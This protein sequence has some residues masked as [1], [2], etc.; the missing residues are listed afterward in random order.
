ME[1]DGAHSRRTFLKVAG[2]AAAAVSLAGCLGGGNNGGGGGGGGNDGPSGTLVYSRGAPSATL[3]PQNSTS[4]EDAKVINQIYN[5]LVQFKPGDVSLEAGLAKKYELSGKTATLTLREGVKFHNDEEFTAEDFKATFRRF[6]DP[7]YEYYP[8]D[9]Y[10]SGYAAIT[11]GNWV[12]TVNAKDKYKLEIQLKQK[13]APFLRNLAMFASAVLSKKAIEEKNKKL[14]KEPVGTGPFKLGQYESNGERIQLEYNDNY[15][16]KGPKVEQVIFSTIPE[17]STRAETLIGGDA[18]IIDGLG[19]TASQK[20]QKADGVKLNAFEGVNTGYMA[21]NMER[22]KPFRKKKVRQAISYAINTKVIVENI[23][24]GFAVQASQ[25]IPSNMMGYNKDLDPYPHDVEK[26]KT[27]LKEAGHGDGISFELATFKN[28]RSYNPSP[29][30]AAQ[31]VRSDLSNVGIEI[32]INQMSFD[33]FLNYTDSGKHDACF[34]GWMSDNADPDNF[35]YSLLHP[36]VES[37]A[38]QDW[39]S[40]DTEGYNTLSVSGWANKEYMKTVEDAQKM[41]KESERKSLYQKA[42]K[43]AHDEAPWVFLDHAKEL[44]GVSN[45]VSG[46]VPSAIG[47]PYLNL[48]SV[49]G[50]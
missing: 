7:E 10:I 9:T 8:G 30:R 16:G 20:V 15:W 42:A 38:G 33:P 29:L 34:L 26:A 44:R 46:Y 21:F 49:G 11:L 25:P 14:N 27:L 41:L 36:G 48:V 1:E 28:P 13:F 6:T 3:D 35:Y 24:S 43:I 47:G 32:E 2:S 12:E 17:N 45:A 18:H 37:P 39:V 4:G 40:F 5:Q 50:E 19:T 31:Q 23:F 22:F